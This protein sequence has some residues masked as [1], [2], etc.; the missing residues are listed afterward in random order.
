M[1]DVPSSDD[2][3]MVIELLPDN[4]GTYSWDSA[5]ALAR[6]AGTIYR[7]VREFWLDRTNDTAGYLDLT[8][9]GLPASQLHDHAKA[10]LQYWDDLIESTEAL[11]EEEAEEAALA[12]AGSFSRK[13]RRV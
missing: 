6:W 5:K 11:A 2:L 7:T 12:A 1:A 9:D 3:V 10:M 4:A 13:I 8:N